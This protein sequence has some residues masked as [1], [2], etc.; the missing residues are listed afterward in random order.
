METDDGE[1]N[2][3]YPCIFIPRGKIWNEY[4]WI[5]LL[6]I[7]EQARPAMTPLRQTGWISPDRTVMVH[8]APKGT[9]DVRPNYFCFPRLSRQFLVTQCR[10]RRARVA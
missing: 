3:H 9:I 7:V 8:D 5:L 2:A 6:D 10:I 1:G 4:V